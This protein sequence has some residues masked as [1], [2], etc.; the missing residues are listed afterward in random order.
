MTTES[1]SPL[2]GARILLQGDSGSGKTYSLSTFVD[3]GVTPFILFT[4][5][6]MDAF[7]R[8]CPEYHFRYIAPAISDWGALADLATKVNQYTYEQLIKMTDTNKSKY[9]MFI[10][11]I[12]A[13]NN[14]TCDV[15]HKEFG[16]VGDWGTDRALC[17]DSLTGLNNAVKKL[18]VGGRPVLHQSEWQVVQNTLMGLLDAW[19]A[20]GNRCW[21][22]MTAHQSIERDESSGTMKR[23]VNTLGK[24]IAPDIPK[25][26][27]DVIET[28]RV[29]STFTWDTAGTNVAVK[30]RNLPIAA[31]QKPTFV[32]IVN[33]WKAKGGIIEKTP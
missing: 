11:F 32:T 19:T 29:G 23:M 22:V 18:H 24:A 5:P 33:N 3:A 9:D 7:P 27:S 14:F 13:N 1:K 15:C 12:K 2:P 8:Q 30:A 20:G 10:Q 21:F 16:D 26:F 31:G 4:E 6:G 17:V 28:I 25:F